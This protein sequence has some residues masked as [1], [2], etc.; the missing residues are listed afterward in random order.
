MA[1]AVNKQFPMSIDE[2]LFVQNAVCVPKRQRPKFIY[3]YIIKTDFMA[4]F[5]QNDLSK[6]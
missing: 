3:N 6:L 1:S 2:I 5:T 4:S